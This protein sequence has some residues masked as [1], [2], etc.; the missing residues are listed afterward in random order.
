MQMSNAE[1]GAPGFLPSYH[2]REHKSKSSKKK[3]QLQSHALSS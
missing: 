2:H 3:K 1:K